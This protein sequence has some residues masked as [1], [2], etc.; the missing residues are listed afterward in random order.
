MLLKEQ[1][2]YFGVNLKLNDAVKNDDGTYTFKCPAPDSIKKEVMLH[3]DPLAIDSIQPY[4]TSIGA[5]DFIS[6]I[7]NARYKDGNVIVTSKFLPSIDDACVVFGF[8]FM[9]DK[10]LSTVGNYT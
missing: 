2:T 9:K 10:E 4:E 1:R 8:I 6:G 5:L 3:G 7:V